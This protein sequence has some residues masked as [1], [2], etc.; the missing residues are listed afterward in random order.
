MKVE[1]VHV[2]LTANKLNIEKTAYMIIGSYKRISSILDDN[3]MNVNT[4][5]KEIKRTKSVK[6]LGVIID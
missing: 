5:G 3:E 4:G 6:S 2:W 1:S